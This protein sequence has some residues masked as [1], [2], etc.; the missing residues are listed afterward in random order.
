MQV[1]SWKIH[2]RR[3]SLHDFG[4][5]ETKYFRKLLRLI[6]QKCPNCHQPTR[7]LGRADELTQISVMGWLEAIAPKVLS[8]SKLSDAVSYAPKQWGYLA[9][10]TEDSGTP[11]DNNVLERDIRAFA[12][13]RKSWLFRDTV[14]GARASAIVYS[15]MLTCRA[16]DVEPLAWLRYVLI[17]LPQHA[18]NTDIN[19]MLPFNFPK[20]TVL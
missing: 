1:A 7:V 4:Y 5:P 17:E 14:E 2:W 19:D 20:A 10:Y 16:Y 15:V 13:G 6:D 3:L 11:I 12:T 18:V 8:N 9:H